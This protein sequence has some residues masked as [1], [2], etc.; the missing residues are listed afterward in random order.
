MKMHSA[1]GLLVWHCM[2]TDL[3]SL[4]EHLAPTPARGGSEILPQKKELPD[5]G[6][7]FSHARTELRTQLDYFNTLI[8]S[9]QDNS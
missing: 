9:C 1:P 5:F 2:V 7:P 6:N 4:C 3:L 8:L